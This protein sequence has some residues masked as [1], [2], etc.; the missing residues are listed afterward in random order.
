[1]ANFTAAEEFQTNIESHLKGAFR[2]V[3]HV[4]QG[5]P[6]TNAGDTAQVR[7]WRAIR[8]LVESLATELGRFAVA[9]TNPRYTQIPQGRRDKYE[10][11]VVKLQA[12]IDWIGANTPATVDVQLDAAEGFTVLTLSDLDCVQ[13]FATIVDNNIGN[14][15]E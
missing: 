12:G 1:M 13:Q 14:E 7:A 11:L 15:I 9:Q 3:Q 10:A 6:A 8:R 2:D 5:C 4:R